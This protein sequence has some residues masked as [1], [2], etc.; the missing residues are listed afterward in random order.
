MDYKRSIDC[1]EALQIDPKH[2]DALIYKGVA[3]YNLKEY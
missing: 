3:Y 1:I 2:T